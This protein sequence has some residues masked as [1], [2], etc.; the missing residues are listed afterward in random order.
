MLTHL[1]VLVNVFENFGV[2]IAISNVVISAVEK[3][4]YN[5]LSMDFG[6]EHYHNVGRMVEIPNP[7]KHDVR[8]RMHEVELEENYCLAL[9]G[10]PVV[11]SDVIF[12]NIVLPLPLNVLE[13]DL[14]QV[15]GLMD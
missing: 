4:D 7:T 5:P 8:I 11:V 2:I 6:I 10:K 1:H 9:V 3:R 15:Y 14:I 13:D 12:V